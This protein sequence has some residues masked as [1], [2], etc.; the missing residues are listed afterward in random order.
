MKKS[1]L[2]LRGRHFRNLYLS[3]VF[4][5]ILH[6]K[7]ELCLLAQST[8]G[9]Y[10]SSTPFFNGSFNES[11]MNTPFSPN[12]IIPQDNWS[13]PETTEPFQALTYEPSLTSGNYVILGDVSNA[14]PI[15]NTLF[16]NIPALEYREVAPTKRLPPL[17]IPENKEEIFKRLDSLVARFTNN[18]LRIQETLP[19]SILQY[20]QLVG[21]RE[22]SFSATPSNLNTSVN[23]FQ[24]RPS[25]AAY[26]LCKNYKCSNRRLMRALDDMPVPVVGFSFQTQRGELLAALARAKVNRNFE[27]NIDD[28][29]YTIK[30]LVEWEK[31]SCSEYANLSLVAVGLSYYIEDPN[32]KWFNFSGQEWSLSQILNQEISRPIDW[33]TEESTNKLIALTYL[34]AKLRTVQ[35][36]SSELVKAIN[37]TETFLC[38]VKQWLI[39]LISTDQLDASLFFSDVQPSDSDSLSN[40]IGVK[41]R[42]LQWLILVS[43]AKELANER[44]EKNMGRLYAYADQT[45]NSTDNLNALSIADT[46]SLVS[47][48]K[49]LILYRRLFQNVN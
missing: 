25:D 12:L 2:Y 32:E 7:L 16:D 13:F 3:I 39:K 8:S 36:P 29:K 38:S 20:L 45:L 41:G 31:Y 40:K 35:S 42:L 22:V 30:D 17:N 23:S 4:L 5:F 37:Q 46:A 27:L 9:Y 10:Q 15:G 34:L 6:C 33:N 28:K 1:I 49:T 47:A 44:L 48:L 43:S 18:Q 19:S 14:I 26:I 21:I 11:S 24:I